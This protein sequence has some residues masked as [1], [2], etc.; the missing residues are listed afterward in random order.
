MAINKGIAILNQNAVGYAGKNLERNIT[1][2]NNYIDQVEQKGGYDELKMVRYADIR[3]N[4]HKNSTVNPVKT[5]LYKFYCTPIHEL[6]TT[7]F[8]DSGTRCSE[9]IFCFLLFIVYS[10]CAYIVVPTIVISKLLQIFYP[11]II[12]GY[13]LYFEIFF[14]IAL[15]QMVMLMVY[16]GLQLI[17]LCLAIRVLKIN[18]WIWHIVPLF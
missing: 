16:M 2:L 13:L 3:T 15:F 10:I 17:L 1:V 4:T 6:V 18:Y 9:R 14:E 11:W 7:G 12:L 5:I 8:A